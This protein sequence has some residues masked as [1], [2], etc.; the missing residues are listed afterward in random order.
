MAGN[1]N[2]GAAK[3][4]KNDEFYTQWNDIE[5]EMQAY[6]EY[7]PDVFRGK[8]VL[9][10]CDDP[11]AS[12]FTKY[13]A[14]NFEKFGLKKLIS[15]SYA[16]ASNPA[17]TEKGQMLL[18]FALGEDRD[19]K[20]NEDDTW[21]RGR[22]Y[23][24]EQ[25]TDLNEDGKLNKEDL[26]WDYLEGDGDFRSEEVTKLRDEAD[27]V[28]T[29]PPF[30]LF[31][32]FLA[33]LIEGDV[34]FSVIGNSNAITY[35]EVFPL[36]KENRLWLGATGNTTDM[37]FRVPQGEVVK[38][39][40][41]AKAARLGY[42][43]TE[44]TTY[45]RLGNSCWFT[46]IEHGRRH[47]PLVLMKMEDNLIYGS[48]RVREIA[49]A[50][51]ENYDAIEVP[52]TKGIPS[53]YEGAM[54]VPISFLD[55]YNPE[56]FEILGASLFDATPMKEVAKPGDLFQ[57]GGLAF[58]IREGESTLRRLYFRLIVRHRHPETKES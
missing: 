36:I 17:V 57:Q 18:D 45:T 37:V 41:K 7:D 39:S 43:S 13:F 1:A 8:T 25:G 34:Q 56:Q 33:W 16:P 11:G 51:Y 21:H 23:V 6:L 46:N 49:Y 2:L 22:I 50:K 20:F 27:I 15:T 12:N 35:K 58:Y 42:P 29:N 31:R 9:L 30:S 24:L 44:T 54:G 53:D 40:D 3:A 10:P 19:E 5:N 4:A 26:K 38:E 48:K 55:K 14:L 47:E 28:V 52:E 32:E